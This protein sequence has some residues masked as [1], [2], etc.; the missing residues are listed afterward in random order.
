MSVVTVELQ[1]VLLIVV[2]YGS[3]CIALLYANEGVFERVIGGCRIRVA[4]DRVRIVGR[5]PVVLNPLTPM[6]PV[7]RAKWGTVDSLDCS[8]FT[9]RVVDEALVACDKMAPYVLAV[10][11]YVV[12][13]VPAVLLTLGATR[14][15]P[16]LLLS[17]AAVVAMLVRLWFLRSQFELS[18]ARFALVAF[19]S[20]ACPPLAA[21]IVRRL[22]LLILLPNDLAR[23]AVKMPEAAA[24]NAMALLARRCAEHAC[25]YEVTSESHRRLTQYG[26]G[27]Y[28]TMDGMR[29]TGVVTREIDKLPESPP[30]VD[31]HGTDGKEP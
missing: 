6:F 14:V 12:V 15:L 3:T 27:L 4:E 23:F 10:F 7:F 26:I 29:A 2:L 25:F 31:I 5:S 9:P 8:N 13:G 11:L 22:S 30:L 18:R 21:G 19:E 16:I 24:V 28:E 1:I 17:Y 20:L